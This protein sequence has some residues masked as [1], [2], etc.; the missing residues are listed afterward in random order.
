VIAGQSMCLGSSRTV[1]HREGKKWFKVETCHGFQIS[2]SMLV[3]RKA[4]R[5]GTDPLAP[6]SH[7]TDAEVRAWI[8]EGV[9]DGTW[10]KCCEKKSNTC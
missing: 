7:V 2:L 9:S 4:D 6:R 10:L 3:P 5:T 8:D 1:L